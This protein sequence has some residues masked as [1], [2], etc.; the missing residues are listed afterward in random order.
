VTE[1]LAKM[2]A[3]KPKLSVVAVI[4]TVLDAPCR[5]ADDQPVLAEAYSE[6]QADIAEAEHRQHV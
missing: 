4:G 3:D 1:Y 5:K 6:R 2:A